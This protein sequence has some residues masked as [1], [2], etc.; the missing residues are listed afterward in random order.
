VDRMRGGRREQ[1]AGGGEGRGS[2]KP[3]AERH[4]CNPRSAAVPAR[5]SGVPVALRMHRIGRSDH[6]VG[7]ETKSRHLIPAVSPRCSRPGRSSGVKNPRWGVQR[8]TIMG[9]ARAVAPDTGWLGPRC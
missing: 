2:G 1:E 5:P 6:S 3:G 4:W 9:A 8:P 7:T